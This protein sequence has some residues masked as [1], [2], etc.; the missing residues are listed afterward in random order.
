MGW[1]KT[2]EVEVPHACHLP[3]IISDLAT[4]VEGVRF[5]RDMGSAGAK[6]VML[7]AG[8]EYRCTCGREYALHTIK[9]TDLTAI[10]PQA[11]DVLVWS[12]I[13]RTPCPNHKPTQHR[14]RKRPWCD[15]CG[16]AED[17]KMIGAGW[18]EEIQMDKNRSGK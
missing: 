5:T 8:S 9:E 15:N 16:R 3:K 11:R 13:T 17:G 14:D 7:G 1:I 18:V 4:G 2:V 12:E 10:Q 6:A